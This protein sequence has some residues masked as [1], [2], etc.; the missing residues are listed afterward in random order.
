MNNQ[1]EALQKI[2]FK[3][4]REVSNH[5]NSCMIKEIHNGYKYLKHAFKILYFDASATFNIKKCVYFPIKEY[6]NT[7]EEAVER[8]VRYAIKNGFKLSKQYNCENFF[9]DFKD[10]P[11]N[12]AFI[13]KSSEYIKDNYLKSKSDF[14]P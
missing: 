9:S 14:A 8:C 13:E 7:D 11:S 6:F 5:L 2:P 12:K 10:V 3:Y 1:K 4:E